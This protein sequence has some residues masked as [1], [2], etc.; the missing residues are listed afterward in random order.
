[1]CVCV[2]VSVLWDVSPIIQQ[3]YGHLPPIA[4]T[5]Q[6]KHKGHSWRSKN[7][8]ILTFSFGPHLTDVQVLDEQLELIYNRS[9]WIQSVV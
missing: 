6:I 1:M 2:C 7:K 4:K 9:V 3:L 5:I 8:L